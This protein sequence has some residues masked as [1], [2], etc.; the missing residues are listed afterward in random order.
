M[1]VWRR[2]C[3]VLGVACA[4]HGEGRLSRA[5]TAALHSATERFRVSRLGPAER[6]DFSSG[7]DVDA[8]VAITVYG[9]L[10]SDEAG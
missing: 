2:R 9:F 6:P 7:A 3:S 8:E 10:P 4:R 5:P 1:S